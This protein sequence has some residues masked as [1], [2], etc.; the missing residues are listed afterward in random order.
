MNKSSL[1]MQAAVLATALGT[2]WAAQAQTSG[3]A[4]N[5]T[6]TSQSQGQMQKDGQTQDAGGSYREPPSTSSPANKPASPTSPDAPA[7]RM[8]TG[9]PGMSGTTGSGSYDTLPATSAGAS[10]AASEPAKHGGKKKHAK[11]HGHGASD[12][13]SVPNRAS[14]SGSSAGTGAEP[15]R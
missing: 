2:A 1:K 11:R 4:G 7:E 6:G 8:G 12:A 15:K 13:A 9:T 5:P 3:T 14:P 10:N